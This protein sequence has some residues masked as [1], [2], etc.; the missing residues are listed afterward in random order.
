M[1]PGS[2]TTAIRADFTHERAQRNAP[3]TDAQKAKNRSK[4][5]VRTHV[6]HLFLHIKRLRG[7]AKTR[8]RGL[9]NNANRLIAMFA[10]YN[11]RRA[12]IVLSG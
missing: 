10:L 7:R 9:A 1:V 12:G 6:E 8:D 2:S 11:V 3:L 4:S 5:A